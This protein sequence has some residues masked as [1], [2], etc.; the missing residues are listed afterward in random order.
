M[1][2]AS[3][4]ARSSEN[5]LNTPTPKPSTGLRCWTRSILPRTP[6]FGVCAARGAATFWGADFAGATAA[7]IAETA[8]RAAAAAAPAPPDSRGRGVAAMR[9]PTP[10]GGDDKR[11]QLRRLTG[12]TRGGHR[13]RHRRRAGADA[14]RLDAGGRDRRRHDDAR[15]LLDRVL[16]G[17]RPA[18]AGH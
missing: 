4:P 8:S 17:E 11:P 5:F 16:D 2:A 12:A 18:G 13:H 7:A 14:A 3:R 15:Q 9:C 10:D 1:S 6:T